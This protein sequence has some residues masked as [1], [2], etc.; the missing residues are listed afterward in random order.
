MGGRIWARRRPTGGSEFGFALRAVQDDDLFDTE[1]ADETTP[2]EAD[3]QRRD[4]RRRCLDA[5]RAGGRARLI[6]GEDRQV[7]ESP[8]ARQW[9]SQSHRLLHAARR[10]H[11]MTDQNPNETTP[12]PAET[13]SPATAPTADRRRTASAKGSEWLVAAPDDDQRHHD[14]GRARRRARSAAKAAELTAVAAVKAGPLAQ[15]AA[16]VT[17]DAGQK[18]AERA[19]VARGRA[20]R[21]DAGDAAGGEA[22]GADNGADASGAEA[23]SR[24]P[25]TR[26]PTARR[27]PRS[28]RQRRDDQQTQP[29]HLA[30]R[31]RRIDD[32]PSPSGARAVVAYTRAAMSVRPIVLLGDPRLRLKGETVDSFGKYLHELLDDLTDRCATR[33]A[34]GLAAPQLGEPLQACVIEVEDKLY[35]LVNPQIVGRPATTATSR[36]ACRSRATSPTSRASEKVWVVAQNR[37]AR[38]SRSPAPGSSAARS[39]TSWTTSTASCTSTTS[40]RWTS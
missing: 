28:R 37:Q 24:T 35:E 9:A 4:G 16:E 14:P 10:R 22:T 39:S 30:R 11:H 32:R 6:A 17:T 3:K 26:R 34:S 18:L 23:P 21:D 40:T 31:I 33:P 12:P 25:R 27:R 8:Q 13:R 2:I 5:T 1:P 15:R 29:R 38:R 19:P 7:H 20:A 36:A